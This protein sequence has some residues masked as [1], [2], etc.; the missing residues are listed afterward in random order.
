MS[1]YRSWRE[2]PTE[3]RTRKILNK[4]SPEE[5]IDNPL[6]ISNVQQNVAIGTSPP[7]LPEEV[8]PTPS[9][10][11]PNVFVP[12]KNEGFVFNPL[13]IKKENINQ[14]GEQKQLNKKPEN[15]LFDQ[16]EEK[17]RPC[18]DLIDSLR[19]LGVEKDLAL[20]AIAVIGDQSSG[21]SSVLEALSGVALPRGSGIVTRCPLELKLKK[22]SSREKWKGKI[23]Y[24]DKTME[25]TYPSEVEKEIRKAQ[26]I[27]A[28]DGV[29][30]S[31]KL[32]S[33]EI[34]SAE[35]PDLTLIDLPGIARVAV[36]N[37]PVDIGDQIKKLIKTFIDKQETINLVVVPSN[38]DIA[39]TEALK[40]AQEVDLNGERTLGILTKPDLMDKGTEGTVVNILRNQVIPL[41]KG[42]MIVKCRGQQDIQ[43]NMALASAIKEERMF[44]EKHKYFR[45][46]LQEKKATIPL[47][48]EKLT[49]ELVE[50]ICRS[51][52]TLEEQISVQLQ[53]TNAEIQRYGKGTPRT[54]GERLY[55]LTDKIQWFNADITSSVQGEERVSENDTR[56]FTKIRKEFQKWGQIVTD[57]GLKIQKSLQP[58][59]WRFENQYRGRELPGF[60]NYK[61]FEI[62]VRNHIMRLE[63]PAVE[64]LNRVTEIVRQGFAEVAKRHFEDF[65]YLYIEAKNR[66]ES[67]KEKQVKEAEA[68]VRIQFAMEQILYCQ[69][70][71]YKCDLRTVK[72]KME[73]S[74][75]NA[76]KSL[77]PMDVVFCSGT[78]QEDTAITETAFHLEAYFK[79][80]GQRLSSQIPL[81]IQF[82]ILKK[83]GDNLQNGMLQ[84]LQQKEKLSVLLQERKD[85]AEQRQFLT[86]RIDRLS[87]ARNHLAKFP[88]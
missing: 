86:D 42:Y 56:L 80:A 64:I 84:L 26:N 54:D 35:V 17:I 48:A 16:Y 61:T 74:S 18:I 62:I 9:F 8:K 69:D 50:H 71:M 37:Q 66:I 49:G 28:G 7:P 23:S 77:H 51:L 52:P 70:S 12:Q 87:Q 59:E 40:M 1:K 38:V 44:F 14:L 41:K 27:I 67:I 4:L 22:L 83:Y 75:S 19:A 5:E 65:H 82:Y 21:K 39:T 85:S 55:F 81:I 15:T 76:K 47:L 45:I 20:P 31:H 10:V 33:L 32:I 53:K 24:L 29:G 11:V 6:D 79:S 46:L 88:S 43:S 30:I 63:I 34:S 57:S 36:G 25:L 72:E 60:V 73:M 2:T 13:P 78:S 3:R 68:T 58:E